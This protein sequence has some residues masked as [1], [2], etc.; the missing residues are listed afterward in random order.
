[1]TTAQRVEHNELRR[2]N[3]PAPA[4]VVKLER[5]PDDDPFYTEAAP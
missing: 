4:A 5:T 2:M 1:M 3:E